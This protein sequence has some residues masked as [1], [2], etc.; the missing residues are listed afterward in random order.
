MV[1]V[2]VGWEQEINERQEYLC[3]KLKTK[4]G[5]LSISLMMKPLAG[6]MVGTDR[7]RLMQ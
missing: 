7:V 5:A 4:C 1:A 2:V 3:S 6:S